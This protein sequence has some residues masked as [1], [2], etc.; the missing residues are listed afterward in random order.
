MKEKKLPFEISQKRNQVV[1]V[2]FRNGGTQERS[3]ECSLERKGKI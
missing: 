3:E 1:V 2:E